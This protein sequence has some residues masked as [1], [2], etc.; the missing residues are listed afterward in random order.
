MLEQNGWHCDKT[1]HFQLHYVAL[2]VLTV[3]C[4]LP[5]HMIN[6]MWS[7]A[8]ETQEPKLQ[9]AD[10]LHWRGLEKNIYHKIH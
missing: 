9:A 6:H 4:F 2:L 1:F 10:T 3:L 8:A 7:K 5:L